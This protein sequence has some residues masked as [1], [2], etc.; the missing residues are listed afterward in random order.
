MKKNDVVPNWLVGFTFF[1]AFLTWGLMMLGG[2]VHGT[3]SSLACPDWPTCHGT[4]F[5]EMQGG[6]LIEHTH[7]LV[8]ASVGVLTIFL[9]I[10]Y[11]KRGTQ[12]RFLSIF[13]LGLVIFQGILGGV[14][15]LFHLPAPVSIS[16]LGASMVFLALILW[17]GL[18]AYFS[19]TRSYS[20]GKTSRGVSGIL[21]FTLGLLFVQILLGAVVRHLG[22]GLACVTLP[23][24]DGSLWPTSAP[25]LVKL[26]MLHRLLG[27]LLALV[28]LL[29]TIDIFIRYSQNF[30]LKILGLV[31][32]LLVAVQITLGWLSVATAL[33][34][35]PVTAHLAIG[36]L[37][38]AS[39][40]TMLFLEKWQ[41]NGNPLIEKLETSPGLQTI[42]DSPV[43]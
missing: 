30:R 15:V 6:V 13:A 21:L 33:E 3:G 22:A 41:S 37:L 36:A 5:P 8:A 14:T 28:V 26:H 11:W 18:L 27:F 20:L 40:V 9:V 39:F 1:V 4:F 16:H 38:W 7:R 17:V 35:L 31:S 2:L 23:F 34:I 12:F 19:K 25:F 32:M 10:F 24:C 42:K 43:S 29:N